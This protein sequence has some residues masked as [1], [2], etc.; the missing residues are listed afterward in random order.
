MDDA[1]FADFPAMGIIPYLWTFA[2]KAPGWQPA[3]SSPIRPARAMV[4]PYRE[5]AA[6]RGAP[7]A[8]GF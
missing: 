2:A 1:K 3:T 5:R 7:R 4:D 8:I 6:I